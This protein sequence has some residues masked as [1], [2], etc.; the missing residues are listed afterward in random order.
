MKVAENEKAG[1]DQEKND[2]LQKLENSK[3]QND[4]LSEKQRLIENE[5]TSLEKEKV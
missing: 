4:D 3:R 5:K 2:L 1:L